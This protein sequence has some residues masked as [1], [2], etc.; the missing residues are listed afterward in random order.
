MQKRNILPLPLLILLLSF[1][2][3][4]FADAGI[5]AQA[6]YFK[7]PADTTGKN[8]ELGQQHAPLPTVIFFIST[9]CHWYLKDSEPEMAT[10]CVN[11]RKTLQTLQH[12]NGEQSNI[13][14]V[15]SRLWTT[16]KE[17]AAYRKKFNIGYPML[18]DKSNEI[19]HAYQVKQV[20]TVIVLDRNGIIRYRATGNIS[21]PAS[22]RA[23]L[24]KA[25]GPAA[26]A[27]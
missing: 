2:H 9:W 5:G 8:I 23:S 15:V 4:S 20:P 21:N 26:P 12:T 25:S 24:D 17:I 16:K 13:V 14:A 7:I 22:L 1:S 11:T 18:L 3:V 19:F 10:A 27:R 6:P